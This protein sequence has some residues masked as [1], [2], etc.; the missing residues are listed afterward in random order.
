MSPKMLTKIL[1][2]IK[3]PTPL[4]AQ[5]VP[6]VNE[7]EMHIFSERYVEKILGIKVIASSR[8]GRN[9]FDIDVLAV[10]ADN[11]PIIIECKWD[12]IDDATIRQLR[13]YKQALLRGWSL[14]EDRISEIRRERVVLKRQEPVLI[15]LGYGYKPS[16]FRHR[17]AIL[18]LSYVYHNVAFEYDPFKQ[19]PRGKVSMSGQWLKVNWRVVSIN[20]TEEKVTFA[21]T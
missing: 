5:C 4:S 10:G 3:D 19:R 8:F 15:A 2:K 18:C 16:V 21:R 9:L 13:R 6:F 11:T 14:F 7:D 1:E 12:L 17:G 20:M